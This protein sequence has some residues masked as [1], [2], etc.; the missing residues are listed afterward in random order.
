[1]GEGISE[2]LGKYLVDAFIY[3]YARTQFEAL[4]TAPHDSEG[5]AGSS[6]SRLSKGD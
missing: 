3:A 6:A 4:T 2:I 1:M 5:N